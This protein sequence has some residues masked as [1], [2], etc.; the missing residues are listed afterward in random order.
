MA[1]GQIRPQLD[2]NLAGLAISGVEGES[3]S[4]GHFYV[5]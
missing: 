3:Q 2:N 5:S 1:G 4:L